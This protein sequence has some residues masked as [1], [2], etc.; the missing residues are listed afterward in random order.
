MCRKNIV[1]VFCVWI[2]FI[3]HNIFAAT[4]DL[5]SSVSSK[6]TNVS[7][8][9]SNYG[10]SNYPLVQRAHKVFARL[11]SVADKRGNTLPRLLVINWDGDPWALCIKDG[12]V[13]LTE[14][15]LKLCY[16]DVRPEIGDSRLA[17]I[18]GHE[19]GHLSKDDYW[20]LF[21]FDTVRRFSRSK[22]QQELEVLLRDNPADRKKKELHADSCG[23]I[24][25]A[26]AGYDPRFILHDPSGQDFF[27]YWTSQ[28]S[29]ATVYSDPIHPSPIERAAFLQ[30]EMKKVAIN[31]EFFFTGVTLYQLGRYEDAIQFFKH[32]LQ[33]FP[34]RE[35]YNNLGLSEFQLTLQLIASCNREVAYQYMYPLVLETQTLATSFEERGFEEERLKCLQ[36]PEVQKHLNAAIYYFKHAIGMDPVYVP[37]MLNLAGIYI[38]KGEPL[39]ARALARKALK[40]DPENPDALSLNALAIY[41]EGKQDNIDTTDR[42]I[43]LMQKVLEQS[44][45]HVMTLYNLASL[46]VQRGRHA[47]AEKYL[48]TFLK[49]MPG[50]DYARYVQ[51][52]LGL[53]PTSPR[54]VQRNLPEPPL[55]FGDIEE[56]NAQKKLASLQRIPFDFGDFTGAIYKSD[57][58]KVLVI[59]D[60]I[61][62]IE[63]VRSAHIAFRQFQAKYG[64]PLRYIKGTYEQFFVYPELAVRVKDGVIK[65]FVYFK[66]EKTI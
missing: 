14:G 25:M 36:R 54:S 2:L 9:I 63:Q 53:K 8:W 59:E 17:F 3:C 1:Y 49:V 5:H 23:L 60:C 61:E 56:S 13:I 35:V 16:K 30:A 4:E 41:L 50:G 18:L 10:Q 28:I 11:V 34:A 38:L 15:A 6:L 51:L 66:E 42:A 29:G 62:I 32:F 27:R 33:K 7:W 44:P 57:I 20:D 21:A 55:A 12:T 45:S 31:L 65:E 24:Y 37:A 22:A 40:V 43:K 52:K 64:Q 19:L 47:T 46:L 39:E 58:F 48:K 26:M